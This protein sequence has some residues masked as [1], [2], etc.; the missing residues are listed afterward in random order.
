MA[1]AVVAIRRKTGVGEDATTITAV[2][3]IS[4]ADD[5]TPGVDNPIEIASSGST[6]SYWVIIRCNITT[7][8]Q[9]VDN[10][11][12]YTDESERWSDDLGGAAN[13]LDIKVGTSDTYNPPENTELNITNYPEL[14]D[15]GGGDRTRDLFSYESGF[16]LG[17]GSGPFTSTG[18]IG[19]YIII[20]VTVKD[21]ALT[22]LVN[23]ETFT[24]VWD[25][26]T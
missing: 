4:A 14:D 13:V 20:Q 6:F 18:D 5:A 8:N 15:L 10:L 22:G 7:V 21:P 19:K 25:P 23:P 2:N 17:A 11:Q 26:V 1:D 12:L 16:P 9:G 24:F 3:R